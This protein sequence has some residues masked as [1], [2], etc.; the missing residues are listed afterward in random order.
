MKFFRRPKFLKMSQKGWSLVELMIVVAVMGIITPALISLFLK[1]S[2]GMAADEMRLQ[3]Q[4]TN[5]NT[6]LRIRDRLLAN[7]HFFQ[8]DGEPFMNRV[9]LGAGAPA[10]LVGS[11]PATFQTN[12]SFSPGTSTSASFGNC[13]FMAV[14]DSSTVVGT[15]NYYAPLTVKT[16]A[17]PVTYSNGA[18]ATLVM[19]VYRF[20][21]YYLSATGAKNFTS[22]ANFNTYRLVEWR[23]VQFADFYEISDIQDPNL[24]IQ[25]VKWLATAG[26]AATGSQA[27]TLAWDPTQSVVTSAFYTLNSAGVTAAVSGQTIPQ[28]DWTYMTHMSPGIMSNGF[29]YGVASNSPP[30]NYV[31]AVPLYGLAASNL[32]GFE[33]GL[34]G[35]SLGEQV[36]LRCLLVAQGSAP[37]IIYNDMTSVDTIRDVW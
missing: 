35:N 13:L 36:L 9:V 21:Y 2:Q 4:S 19:D 34:E 7:R 14:Y 10:T 32:G 31:P 26:T 27:I 6:L 5:S 17:I 22:P 30:W 20:Y 11:K 25:V 24:Q 18:P 16:G 37:K 28:S 12:S 3:L 23:S 8:P 29:K 15:Q 33:V 1:L